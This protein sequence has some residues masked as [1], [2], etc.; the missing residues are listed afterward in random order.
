MCD[1]KNFV[2]PEKTQAFAEKFQNFW[3][4]FKHFN[5][6]TEQYGSRPVHRLLPKKMLKRQVST[7]ETLIFLGND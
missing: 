1:T 4:E 3:H 6:K 2:G 7:V 5:L